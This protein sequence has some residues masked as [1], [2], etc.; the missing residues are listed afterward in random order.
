ME[1]F[2][3]V[4]GA[5]ELTAELGYATGGDE[6]EPAPENGGCMYHHDHKAEPDMCER[7]D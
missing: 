2:Y 7:H 3:P 4:L 5:M 1:A 6:N